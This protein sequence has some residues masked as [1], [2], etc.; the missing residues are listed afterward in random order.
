MRDEVDLYHYINESWYSSHKIIHKFPQAGRM[1][2]EMILIFL[3][4]SLSFEKWL[5][6]HYYINIHFKWREWAALRCLHQFL[7]FFFSILF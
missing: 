2:V 5:L 4:C 3:N 6:I 1:R 7:T